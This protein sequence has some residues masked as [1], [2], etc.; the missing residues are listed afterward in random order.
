M[1]LELESLRSDAAELKSDSAVA[2]AATTVV[3]VEPPV[4][5]ADDPHALPERGLVEILPAAEP[6]RPADGCGQSVSDYLARIG[7]W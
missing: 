4:V 5:A 3:A 2:G 6:R 7:L 1:S